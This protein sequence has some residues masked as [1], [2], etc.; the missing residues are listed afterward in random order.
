MAEAAL[1]ALLDRA[2]I[3]DVLT[4]Y[5]RGVDRRDLAL[6]RS[7]FTAGATYDGSLAHGTIADALAALP[8]ALERYTRTFHFL[9]NQTIDVTGDAAKSETY[10]LAHHEIRGGGRN[11][12]AIRYEDALVR[13]DDGAWRIR[14][15][16]VHREWTTAE[17]EDR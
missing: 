2:A 12:V 17:K 15:R 8:V 3:Q 14:G 13:C 16:V 5:A 9:G 11:V 1:Q 10:C 4:R 6:V 7:C